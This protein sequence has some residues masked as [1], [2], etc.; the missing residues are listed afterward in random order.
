MTDVGMILAYVAPMSVVAGA[1]WR[2]SAKL[3]SLERHV[4]QIE[5]ENRQLRSDLVSLQT[6]LS[7]LVDSRRA[8]G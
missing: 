3:T 5:Q 6:L 7:L 2:I 4:R 8:V 1:A